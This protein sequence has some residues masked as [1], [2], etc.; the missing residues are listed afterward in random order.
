MPTD[1]FHW[2]VNWID[3]MKISRKHFEQTEQFIHEQL[4]DLAAQKLTDYQFGI[5]PG[6]HS[7]NL[8]VF[9]D[10]NQQIKTELNSCNAVTPNGSR[11]QVLPQ[12]KLR[13]DTSLKEVAAKFGLAVSQLQNI[14]IV[15][16]V[17]PFKRVP[18]GEPLMGENPPR[19]PFTRSE[20][21]LDIIPAEQIIATQMSGSLII[22][23]ISCSNGELIFQ[24]EFIPACTSMNSLPALSDWHGKFRLLLENWEQ[25]CIK[26][27]QKTYSKTQTQQSN[28]L[29]TSIQK[30]TEKILEKLADEKLNYRWIIH[31]SA[32]IYFCEILLKNIHFIQVILNFYP[33]REKEEM[34]NYFAEWTDTQAGNLEVQT[35]RVLQIQYNHYDV[36][37]VLQ[38]IHQAYTIYIQIFMKLSQLEFIGKK[39][40]QNI[41]VIE[42]QVK[43]N[44][45]VTPP[46]NE[47]PNNRWS[48]LS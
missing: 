4:R 37:S 27:V 30:L 16:S 36:A 19:H 10:Y 6:E 40:G 31:Q 44:K 13:F 33:E 41:F 28:T 34:L 39:K 14:Y 17:D 20:L 43:D 3:G 7:L 11:I 25:Y 2:P 21:K 48:P 9:C 12:D 5:L 45:Q 46:P 42:Q 47:K 32:P 26:V 18:T 35:L 24:K 38:E 29:A 23:K 22:G 15:L 8:N 1:L